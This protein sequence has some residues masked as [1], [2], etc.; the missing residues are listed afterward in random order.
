VIAGPETNTTWATVAGQ[1]EAELVGTGDLIQLSKGSAYGA[2][3]R[4]RDTIT[5]IHAPGDGNRT[6]LSTWSDSRGI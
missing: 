1:E 6:V 2:P 3:V 4:S 5:I